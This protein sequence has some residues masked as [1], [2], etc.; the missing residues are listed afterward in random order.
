MI[1]QYLHHITIQ[2][3]L[4]K[5][6]KNTSGIYLNKI[7]AC[8]FYIRKG[9]CTTVSLKKNLPHAENVKVSR[10]AIWAGRKI[11][12]T[13]NQLCIKLRKFTSLWA[14]GHGCLFRSHQQ[15]YH[16]CNRFQAMYLRMITNPVSSYTISSVKG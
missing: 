5:C 6:Y 8:T 4:Q 3:L 2:S 15:H 9:N 14:T 16:K 10:N 1:L 7:C 12:S 11:F 13:R